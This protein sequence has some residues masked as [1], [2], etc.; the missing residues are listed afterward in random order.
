MHK[1]EPLNKRKG[2]SRTLIEQIHLM[3]RTIVHID[4][5]SSTQDVAKKTNSMSLGTV[6]VADVQDQGRGQHGHEWISPR[7]GLYASMVLRNDPLIS[8]RVGVAVARALKKLEIDAYLK[9]P[10]DVV[11]AGKK[12]AGILIEAKG[13]AAVVGI[14]LNID[15]SP[16]PGST[17]VT[18]QTKLPTSRDQLL[19]CI[20]DR[21]ERTYEEDII[22]AYRQLCVTIGQDVK[23]SVGRETITG[24]VH[25]ISALGHLML[26][27]GDQLRIIDSGQCTHLAP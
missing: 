3:D 6:V 23:V 13:E 12:I 5:V 25:S 15:T 2:E 4:R 14:G 8:V 20:L 26:K 1:S 16:L 24:H 18:D 10:N 7:G 17:C 27:I 22:Q 21:L 9:W 11:V 19:R